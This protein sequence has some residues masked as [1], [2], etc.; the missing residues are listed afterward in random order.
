MKEWTR[1][2]KY[3]YLKDIY[4]IQELH[5]RIE[6]SVYRQNYHIQAVSGLLNDPNGFAFFDGNWHMFYQWCP[7]GAVHGLKYWYHT[8]SPDLV[9][10]KDCGIGIAPDEGDAPDNKGAYSGSG[11]VQGETLYLYYT[12]NHRDREYVRHPFTLLASMDREGKIVKGEKPLFSENPAYTEHQ[13]DPKIVYIS[14][15]EKY[16]II[17]GAQ[18]PDKKGRVIVYESKDLVSG[19]TF[20]GELSVPGY[21]DLGIMWECPS[22]EHIDGKD[23]LIFCPQHLSLPGRGGSQN[24]NT[25]IVGKMDW[26]SLT[27]VPEGGLEFLDFGFD[28]YAAACAAGTQRHILSAWMGLPDV[29][30]PTDEEEWSGCLVLP[31]ELSVENGKLMQR[32]PKELEKLRIKEINGVDKTVRL[33]KAAELLIK[34]SVNNKDFTMRLFAGEDGQGGLLLSYEASSKI[35]EIDRS[36]METVFNENEGPQRKQQLSDSLF[37]LRIFIDSSSIEIFVNNGEAVFTSRVFPKESENFLIIDK[38]KAEV[39][40][41]ELNRQPSGI[42]DS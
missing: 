6:K 8:V 29:S 31:R 7:W 23:V 28:F 34:P 1:E 42:H 5:E 3:R 17:L 32:P 39:K 26:D 2:E 9:N 4:E 24:H 27:F 30:Y 33:P 11:L 40:L 14:E 37:E 19:Y 15:K 20:A 25:Y 35:L 10:W 18:T 36:G 16:Y 13:R 22:I 38:G 12:G 21:D 41:W